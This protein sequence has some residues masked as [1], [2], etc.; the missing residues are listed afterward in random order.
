MDASKPTGR[1]W[2]LT[3]FASR[4]T[5]TALLIAV[6]SASAC[7]EDGGSDRFLSIGT[8]GTGGLYYPIGGGLA[9][10]LT[11]GDSTR[12]YT[13]EVTGGSVENVNRV[14]AGQIDLAFS[15]AVTLYEAHHGGGDYPTPNPDL[16]IVAPLYPN[17]VHV[18]LGRG[19]DVESFDDL[20]GQRVS[21]GSAGSGTEQTSR[22]LLEVHG[23]SYDDIEERFL[24]FNESAAALRDGALEAAVISVGYPAAAVLEATT[25]G[26]A[27][28]LALDADAVAKLIEQYP[29]YS[30]GEIPP[31]IYPGIETP[32]RTVAMSNWI[33]ARV[34]LDEQ[35]VLDLLNVLRD[36]RVSLARIHEM[37]E[38]IDLDDL[39]TA[40]IA[41]H[42]A[43]ERWMAGG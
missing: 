23:L 5:P 7:L 3:D 4:I 19:A 36:E 2:G 30:A 33:V 24:S 8:G 22:Q 10:R 9:A 6:I 42:P 16:R 20:R 39:A 13:A 27:R 25:S 15:L 21:V 41:L 32:V 38:Q 28:L 12:Q 34:D 17:V 11:A 37:V 43:V 31:G 40:P 29:Y 26:G 14:I 35:V 18:V 1:G